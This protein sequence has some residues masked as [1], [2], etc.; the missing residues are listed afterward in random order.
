MTDTSPSLPESIEPPFHRAARL[1]AIAEMER[2]LPGVKIDKRIDLP[3]Q[4]LYGVTA[5]MVAAQSVD[6]ADVRTLD[7]L[8]AHG[9]DLH[10]R[11]ANG[12]TAAWH[13]AGGGGLAEFRPWRQMPDHTERLR[14]LL[15]AG[16]SPEDR[17]IN[18][19]SLMTQ[20]C[21]AG[22]PARIQLLLDWGVSPHP[23]HKNT[24]EHALAPPPNAEALSD[25]AEASAP[26]PDSFYGYQIPLFCAVAAGSVECLRLLL[27]AGADLHLR[28]QEEA[29]ALSCTSALDVVLALIAAGADPNEQ[30]HGRDALYR[31]VESWDY[32]HHFS[33]AEQKAAVQA[34]LDAGVSTDSPA[35]TEW[36]ELYAAAFH[37]DA[38]EVERLLAEGASLRSLRGSTPLH[39]IAWQSESFDQETN[40]ACERIIR[41]LVAAGVPIDSQDGKGNTALHNAVVE[42]Y[43]DG[44]NPTA[45]RVLLEFGAQPDLVNHEGHTPLHLAANAGVLFCVEALLAAGADPNRPDA[46]GDTPADLVRQCY[47]GKQAWPAPTDSEACLEA[48]L[49]AVPRR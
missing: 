49:A 36:T 4:S 33:E 6:G 45:V 42:F 43:S 7:W 26:A 18:G 16:L 9:A 24:P 10:A 1:G 5:L 37:Q 2:L 44:S 41:M 30:Y 46:D 8:L 13:C 3:E 15:D 22:D 27:A 31:V 48:L 28:D 25:A 14:F 34:L 19:Q 38:A 32:N 35:F 20:A 29:S 17:A 40:L 11:S 23:S 21:R 47:R 12:A 39:A